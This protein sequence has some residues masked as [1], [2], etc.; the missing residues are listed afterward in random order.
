MNGCVVTFINVTKSV[1]VFHRQTKGAGGGREMI[2]TKQV[3]CTSLKGF[4][5]LRHDL[6]FYGNITEVAPRQNQLVHMKCA[7][8]RQLQSL[9]LFII[10][11]DEL[12]MLLIHKKTDICI[13]M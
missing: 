4:Q 11:C 10:S 2:A 1:S 5:R 7:W 3:I 13:L 8:R 6:V 9:K 12:S